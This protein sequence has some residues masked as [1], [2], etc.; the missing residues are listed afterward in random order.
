M[1]LAY[2]GGD[3]KKKRR[4]RPGENVFTWM[5]MALSLFI[6]IMA[7]RISGFS[8]ISSPGAFPMGAGLVMVVSAGLLLL[9][10]RKLKKPDVESFADEMKVVAKTVFPREFLIYIVIIIG[11]MIII[12]PIHFL[13][14]SFIFMVVSMITLRGSGL[15]KSLFISAGTLAAIYLVFQ[16]FF[17]V[18]MP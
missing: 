4:L 9:G 14:S 17:R 1:T 18:V 2:W 12:E 6:L 10:N 3:V 13:P 15:V 11:Y 8:S 16:F 7:Y 5:M